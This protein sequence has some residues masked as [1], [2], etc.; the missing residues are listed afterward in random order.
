MLIVVDITLIFSIL[1]VSL[2]IWCV[3]LQ[4]NYFFFKK[5]KTIFVDVV[6]FMMIDFRILLLFIIDFFFI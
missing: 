1:I 6:N 2:Y 3:L 4:M 5:K